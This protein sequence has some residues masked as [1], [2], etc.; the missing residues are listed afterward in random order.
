MTRKFNPS[1]PVGG[2]VLIAL[3][4]IAIAALLMVTLHSPCAGRRLPT[5]GP[6]SGMTVEW[7][8]THPTRAAAEYAWCHRFDVNAPD[9][10]NR[11]PTCRAVDEARGL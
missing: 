9:T 4:G 5:S 7:Y 11:T 10:A 6:D 3:L 1:R 2:L 8:V